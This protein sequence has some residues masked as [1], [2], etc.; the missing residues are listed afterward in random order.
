[1]GIRLG[2]ILLVCLVV[3]GCSSTDA[4]SLSS[5]LASLNPKNRALEKQVENDP[6][7]SADQPQ[8]TLK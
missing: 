2:M 3:G 1:M 6:F 5:P 4:G 7:P 8:L